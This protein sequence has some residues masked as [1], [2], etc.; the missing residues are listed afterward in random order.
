MHPKVEGV[1]KD[2]VAQR[3]DLHT[4][5]FLLDLLDQVREQTQ[6]ETVPDTFSAKHK[7]SMDVRDFLVVG[8]AS[9]EEAWHVMHA[10]VLLGAKHKTRKIIQ[11]RSELFFVHGIES[12][13]Q[14][15]ELEISLLDVAQNFLSVGR[16]ND[17][18][19]GQDQHY[20]EVRVLD[21][22]LVLNLF[23]DC[24]LIKNV[25]CVAR[26]VKET[27]CRMPELYHKNVL[28]RACL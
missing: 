5:V 21:S 16:T 1:A 27:P 8:L 17:L 2:H 20:T 15:R 18:V 13:D 25:D 26:L 7:R 14:V 28:A 19:A 6:L 24:D 11:L 3:T 12:S 23:Y 22:N 4:Y 10:F 9:V